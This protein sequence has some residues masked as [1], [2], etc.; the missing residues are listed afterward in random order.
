MIANIN[1]ADRPT[2]IE[3]SSTEYCDFNIENNIP[4][5]I[6]DMWPILVRYCVGM[7]N[8]IGENEWTNID[9]TVS[10]THIPLRLLNKKNL[11]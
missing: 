7:A 6:A 2:V 3:P 10:I 8:S 9:N 4:C 1:V 5:E 11:K